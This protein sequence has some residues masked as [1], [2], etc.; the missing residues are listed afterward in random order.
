MFCKL[1]SATCFPTY[2]VGIQPVLLY[3]VKISEGINN[4][5]KVFAPSVLELDECFFHV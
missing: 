2:L 4:L 3:N 1:S 5:G